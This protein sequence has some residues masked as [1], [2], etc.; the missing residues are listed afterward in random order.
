MSALREGEVNDVFFAALD[1]VRDIHQNCKV[2]T[3]T[4]SEPF[5]CS[6]V[7]VLTS[8][9]LSSRP[10]RQGCR[11]QLSNT[12]SA[13]APAYWPSQ[14]PLEIKQIAWATP[15]KLLTGPVGGQGSCGWG[16]SISEGAK[17]AGYSVE[18]LTCLGG[19]P[20]ECC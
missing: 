8:P 1:H 15:P 9:M 19:P 3:H 6:E 10:A 14:P 4:A 17:T 12:V 16:L 11:A 18:L 2:K 13:T 7:W 20:T 5:Q